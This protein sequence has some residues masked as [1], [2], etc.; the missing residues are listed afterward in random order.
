[1]LLK[2]FYDPKLAQ[3]SYM[4]GCPK[5][6]EAL[7]VDPNREIDQCLKAAE[8]EGLRITHVTETH[9]HAD[10]VSGAANWPRPRAPCS[11]SATWTTPT[12]NTDSHMSRT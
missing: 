7:I 12:G 9:I 6:G 5:S 4:V 10:Y 1:M 2:Y 11:S 8:Q 3:A